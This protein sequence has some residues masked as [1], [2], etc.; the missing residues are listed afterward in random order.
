[1]QVLDGEVFDVAVD[2]RVGS[3][4]FGRWEGFVLSAANRRQAYAPPGL[5]H[6]FCVLSESA[7]FTYKCTE[8]Y[9]R[10]V[11]LGIAWARPRDRSRL[12]DCLSGPVGEGCGRT[13]ALGDRGQTVAGLGSS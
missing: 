10:E 3:P 11:E 13:E 2:V 5:A 4:T 7:L 9:R 12:A 6:G 8:F 1:M